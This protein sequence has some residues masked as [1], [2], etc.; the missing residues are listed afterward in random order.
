M[1]INDF[2][3]ECFFGK[4]EFTAPYLL[5]QSDC[6]SMT[7]RELLAMESG[8]E[9][10]YL[11]QWLGYTETWGDP[12]LRERIA[13]LYRTMRME[14]IL[15]FHGAQ[16]AIFLL[17][18]VLLDAGDH[19]IAMFPNYQSAYELAN[20][21]PGCELTKWCQKDCG[22]HWEMDLDELEGM[23][24]P[25]TKLVCVCSPANPTGFTF[26]NEEIRRLTQVC[27]RHGVWLFADEVYKGLELDGEPRDWMADHY[28]KCISLGVMSKA[29][30]LAGLRVGWLACRDHDLLE[31]TVK[32]KH[33]TSICDSAPSE[34]LAEIALR[35][36]EEILDR[37][38]GII[39]TNLALADELFD[40]Y[41]GMFERKNMTCGPVAFHKLLLPEP[42]SDFC[43][44]AVEEKG[45][46][47]M[48]AEIF[49]M[50]GQYF[51]MGY[52][53]RNVPESLAVFEEFLRTI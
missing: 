14:D 41:P 24:R 51:R 45:V 50:E 5:T 32:M 3:L 9:E 53:R 20:S 6:E 10:A 39:R 43:Q 27:R 12:R 37:N 11:D 29:Y 7:A 40:R 42:V 28:E 23:I 13:G 46:L 36:S 30:G 4:Y 22:D 49:D 15:V 19:M 16:E 18:N 2:K 38:R 8:A 44:R 35:H 48:P 47:L 52:G 1:K 25:N 31:R 26:T 34:F 21:I 17:M 33:Y